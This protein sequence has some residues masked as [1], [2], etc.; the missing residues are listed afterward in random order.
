MS[1]EASGDLETVYDGWSKCGNCKQGFESALGLEMTRRF[2]RR[3][4][5]R[6]DLLEPRYLSARSLAVALGFNAEFDAA[7]Q[8]LDEATNCVGDNTQLLVDL[9]LF[10][11]RMLLR[12]GQKLE[13]L[14][15]LQAM[16]PEAKVYTAHPEL[17][18]HAMNQLA[19]VFLSLGRYQEAREM[20]A[21]LVAFN[22]ATFG[23]EDP[24]TLQAISW[25]AIACGKLGR[26]EEAKVTFEAVLRN[27]TRVLGRDHPLTQDT[28]KSMQ[29]CGFVVPS[30]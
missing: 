26:V 14:G 1:K 5:S 19:S 4:Q 7:H 17:Y 12:S 15:L 11:A 2:W 27:I 8:L 18:A 23:L 28:W 10:R 22:K 16:L 21:E 6:R 9:K 13:A 20:T 3:H 30:G 25:Y 24:K 29:E